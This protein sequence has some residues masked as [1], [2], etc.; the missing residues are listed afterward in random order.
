MES[1]YNKKKK[2]NLGMK[3]ALE[4]PN[5]YYLCHLGDWS[6]LAKYKVWTV[7]NGKIDMIKEWF[8][9]CG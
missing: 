6:P 2:K 8:L 7:K 9:K 1:Y 3:R 5:I 4:F